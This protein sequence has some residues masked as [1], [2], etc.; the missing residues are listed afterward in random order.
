MGKN[1]LKHVVSYNNEPLDNTSRKRSSNS[2]NSD[3]NIN[4]NKGGW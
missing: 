4:S 2:N 3:H 1:E